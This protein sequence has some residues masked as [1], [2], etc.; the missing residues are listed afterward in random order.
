MFKNIKDTAAVYHR[1][2]VEFDVVRAEDG[3][4][5]YSIQCLD[6]TPQ[7]E[8]AYKQVQQAQ[9]RLGIEAYYIGVTYNRDAIEPAAITKIQELTQESDLFIPDT[10]TETD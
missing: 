9:Q 1:Q 7:I 3:K 4:P 6:L 10:E 2:L 8:L 5:V